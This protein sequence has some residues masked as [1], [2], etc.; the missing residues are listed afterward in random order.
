MLGQAQAIG[1]RTYH[2]LEGYVVVA[3]V[4]IAASLLLEKSFS[5]MERRLLPA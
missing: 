3:M 5:W 4:F 1:I 2:V